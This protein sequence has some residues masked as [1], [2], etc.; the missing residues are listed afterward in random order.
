MRRHVV[1]GALLIT[2]GAAAA[3]AVLAA[4]SAPAEFVGANRCRECHPAAYQAWAHSVH[5]RAHA[6]L[7]KE[8]VSDPRC[9]QCHGSGEDGVGSVQ[10]ESCHG[11]G[12]TY[13]RTYVMKDAEL[14]RLVGLAE[15]TEE[16]CRRCHTLTTPAIRP[17]EHGRRWAEIRHGPEVQEPKVP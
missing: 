8:H 12:Q 17:Y 1:F 10:C 9:T 16:T 11:A 3:A 6:G 13:A 2:V 4:A 15:A 14:S 5:A 7:P